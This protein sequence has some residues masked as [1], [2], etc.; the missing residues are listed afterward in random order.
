MKLI[1]RIDFLR[2][3]ADALLTVRRTSDD[4]AVRRR[5][6]EQLVRIRDRIEEWLEEHWRRI[7]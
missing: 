3:R 6:D 4:P 5:A 7:P 2:G 1:E